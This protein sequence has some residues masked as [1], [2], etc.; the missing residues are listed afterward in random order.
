MSTTTS[1][2]SEISPTIGVQPYMDKT[3]LNT[4]HWTFCDKIRFRNGSPEAIWNLGYAA[5]DNQ[6]N[7][8][9]INSGGKARNFYSQYI[10]GKLY[11]LIGK[12]NGVYSYNGSVVTNITPL[13]DTSTA[14]PNSLGTVYTTLANNPISTIYG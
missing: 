8:L 11:N 13:Q 3:N 10:N 7:L 14:I 6:S 12:S 1:Q 9:M 5:L 2:I 4:E